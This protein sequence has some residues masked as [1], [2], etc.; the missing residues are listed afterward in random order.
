MK[1]LESKNN[2]LAHPSTLLSKDGCTEGAITVDGRCV[3]YGL[4]HVTKFNKLN[5]GE[6]A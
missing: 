1:E 4:E 2:S 3:D 5:A 6:N